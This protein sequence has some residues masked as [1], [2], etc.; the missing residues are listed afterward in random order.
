[1]AHRPKDFDVSNYEQCPV[2][3]QRRRG[4]GWVPIS[5]VES[6]RSRT[7]RRGQ[8]VATSRSFRALARPRFLESTVY[9]AQV[10]RYKR[11]ALSLAPLH[12][13]SGRWKRCGE[14]FRLFMKVYSRRQLF[15]NAFMTSSRVASGTRSALRAWVQHTS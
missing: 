12:R 13:P 3:N 15:A 9:G 1:P 4:E 5:V 7:Q 10:G 6:G 11:L 14:L 2:S 8:R